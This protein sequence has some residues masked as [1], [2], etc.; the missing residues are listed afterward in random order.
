LLKRGG[1]PRAVHCDG[2][3][4]HRA[5]WYSGE[6]LVADNGSKDDSVHIAEKLGA[7]VIHVK[8][9][10]CGNALRGGIRAASGKWIVMGDAD[11][12]LSI[13][14]RLAH[15]PAAF[16]RF[17]RG[18]CPAVTWAA[19][20][21]FARRRIIPALAVFVMFAAACLGYPSR[22]GYNTRGID[23]SQAWDAFHFAEA[24]RQSTQFVAQ[25]HF[26]EMLSLEPGIVLSDIAAVYLNALLPDSFVAAP[27]DGNHPYKWSKIWR[28]EQPQALA[29]VKRS[30]AQ[31]LL[32]YALFASMEETATAR[33]RLPAIPSHQWMPLDDSNAKAI[34]LKLVPVESEDRAA[35]LIVPVR[36]AI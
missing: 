13:W 22:S 34:I 21:L 32:V 35:P 19:N 18:C 26:A 33:S 9:K 3:S 25:K 15:L 16:N 14:Q 17:G 2:A 8:G 11:V 29:F 27:I 12:E 6:I 24:P 30:L 4:W 5:F 1:D 23:R 7:R 20:S 10:G 31:S 28:Y 36:K